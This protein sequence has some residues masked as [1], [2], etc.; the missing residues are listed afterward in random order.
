MK[1]ADVRCFTLA[2][3]IVAPPI[4][5]RQVGMLD[6]YP[7]FAARPVPER[8]VDADG[9]SPVSGAYVEI[10]SD[11]GLIGVFGPIFYETAVLIQTK[12][13]PY[14]LAQDPLATERL[15]DIMYRQDR[16][17]R[18]GYLMMAISAA[19]N[20]LWDLKGKFFG[21]PVYRLLGGPTRERVECYASMLGHSLEL[22]RV[23]ERAQ[24]A[25]AQGFK[26]QKW[27]FRY[28]PADGLAGM[29][30][31][32]EL[33]RTV[34]EAVGPNIEI[35]FDSWMGWD[36]TY[37][38]RLVERIEQ[39]DPRWVEESVP[40]DRVSDFA[41]IRQSTRVPIATGEH[42]YTRW[43]FQTLLQADAI[44]VIQ[45]DPDWCGGISELVKICNLAS[46]YGRMVI[47]HGH[48]VHPAVHVIAAQSPA[49]CPMAET[50][51]MQLPTKQHFHTDLMQ[52]EGGSIALP[53]APGLGIAL[54]EAKIE[55]RTAITV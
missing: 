23:T 33:A 2:G 45:A 13:R 17:A 35:M 34:R 20:A 42:E 18:K 6:V 31:N 25:V 4:E 19:D 53:T 10:E 47:P 51:L 21:Q 29:A 9:A 5:A 12:L 40:M 49:T 16:H 38:I 7:E 55:Q 11:D 32:V 50:L 15:W 52:P 48:S 41:M 54:D 22:D 44:D 39:Y 37:T 27:F 3:R 30:Q 24:W 46:A 26:A 1:I 43:G 14:L 36:A 8:K 28:G